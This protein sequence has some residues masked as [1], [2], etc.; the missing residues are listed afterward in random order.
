VTDHAGGMTDRRRAWA[1]AIVC[2]AVAVTSIDSLILNLALPTL[3]RDLDVS[4]SGLQWIVDSYLLTFAGF[5]LVGG[6]LSDRYGRALVMRVGLLTF[7]AASALGAWSTSVTVLVVARG[8]MGAGGAL[9]IPSTIA[10]VSNLY[11]D[12]RQRA[13][14]LGVWAGIAG[15]GF[16][17]GPVLG[18]VLLS[19]FWWGSV[20]LINVPVAVVAVIVGW[21]TIPESRD[22]DAARFDPVGVV[23]SVVSVSALVW[24]TIEA[25]IHGWGSARTVWSFL[26][27]AVLIGAFVV[28][29]LTCPHAMLDLRFFR[30]RR[31]SAASI[32]G[33][34][35]GASFAGSMFVVGQLLQSVLGH[36]PLGAGLRL[37]PLAATFVAAGFTGPRLAEH[38]GTNRTVALGLVA[39]A[40][41]VGA[42][43]L[44]DADAGYG[45]VLLSVALIGFGFG[46]QLGPNTDAG[47]AAVSHQRAGVASGM[48]ATVR[49]IAN[50]VG[51]AVVGSLLVSGYRARLATT[52]DNLEL[53]AGARHDARESVGGA[54]KT[55]GELGGATGRALREGARE[56]FVHGERLGMV[57]TAGFLLAAAVIAL[58]SL[59]GR[60]PSPS[61]PDLALVVAIE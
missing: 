6:S 17:L 24:A 44:V 47:L 3:S 21:W 60:S 13:R 7:G 15:L 8:I 12:P 51:V 42:L 23:L 11:T 58:R 2:G 61:D 54:L 1:L 10:I 43:A 46:A 32:V 18:G 55:A 49:N 34:V 5:V 56:A 35:S 4:T 48:L 53:P 29:E 14:A 36:D 30:N 59:P 57:V 40:A 31:F 33:S 27:A 26:G 52:T 20:F 39:F 37:V 22:P 45:W 16:A 28:W 19:Q 38:L 9:L 50:S 41:G 25:P